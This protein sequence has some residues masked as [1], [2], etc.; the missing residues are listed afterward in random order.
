MST[1]VIENYALF[2]RTHPA[3]ARFEDL[4]IQ[5]DDTDMER[6]DLTHLTTLAEQLTDAWV[7]AVAHAEDLGF[8]ALTDPTAG[9][10]ASKIA[11]QAAGA[12]GPEREA[13]AA[14]LALMLDVIGIVLPQNRRAISTSAGSHTAS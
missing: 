8:D 11:S 9:R 2:D 7:E 13:F 3:T 4:L 12:T 14:R 5:V 6:C 1:Y 10:K